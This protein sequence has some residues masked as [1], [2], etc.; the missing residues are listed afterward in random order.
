MFENEFVSSDEVQKKQNVIL[1]DDNNCRYVPVYVEPCIQQEDD[2]ILTRYLYSKEE[3]KHSILVSM[4]NHNY[5]ETLFWV[6]ELYY[7]GFEKETFMFMMTLYIKYYIFENPQ[8]IIYIQTLYNY[9]QENPEIYWIIGTIAATLASRRHQIDRFVHILYNSAESS[10]KE[11][12]DYKIPQL[13][14]YLKP[15]DVEE[16]ATVSAEKEK[17]R[18][19]LPKVYRYQVHKE[20]AYI[21]GTAASNFK[22]AYYY[23]WEYYAYRSPIWKERFDKYGATPNHEKRKMEFHDD[24]LE[25]EFYDWY[26]Y[27]PDEQSSA[28]IQKSTGNPGDITHSTQIEFS[29]FAYDLSGNSIKQTVR[30]S[31]E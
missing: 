24:D 14:I 16:Y 22:D 10:D 15:E 18:H 30:I 2:I 12:P 17:A 13:N 3:V 31:L 4:L 28:V 25:E 20:V 19:L 7:S 8:T 11:L 29:H 27:E 5:D 21:F 1:T 9:W 23:H 26:S 6:Y